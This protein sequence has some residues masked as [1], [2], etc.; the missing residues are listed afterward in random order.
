[1]IG[2]WLVRFQLCVSLL[3]LVSLLVFSPS[4]FLLSLGL[5]FASSMCVAALVTPLAIRISSIIGAMDV[6]GGRHIHL[7]ATPRLGG[8][9]VVTGV[10]AALLL[11]SI[12]YMP[13]LR[14]LLMGSFLVFFVGLLDDVRP[15]KAS[16]KLLFQVVACAFLISDGVH[17]LFFPDTWW[18]LI[19]RWGV[20]TLWI[21]GITNAVN[22]LD[23]MDGL[24][25]GLVMG[26]SAIYFV[27]ALLLGSNMLAYCSL[28]LFCASFAFLGYNIKPA[29]IFLGDGGSTFLGFFLAALSVQGSWAKNNPLVSFFI[30]VLILSVPIYDM[31]FT[32]VSRIASGRVNSFRSWLEYTGRDHLHHRL[33]A[34]GFSRGNVV[35]MICLLNLGV[36]MGAIVIFES[37]TYG[38]ITMIAQTICIYIFI[39]LLE[40]FGGRPRASVNSVDLKQ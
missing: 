1:M 10:V 40:V 21:V 24:L 28:A 20:T 38:G 25:S 36:G 18:G 15:V 19:G 14:A 33:E 26:T 12:N 5:I 2:P 23:G 30:P 16:V 37:K 32:T 9:A 31:I 35:L 4:P 29:R 34:L 39:A 8:I 6:P 22:F 11:A 13:N 7:N 17:V 3:V 27:L